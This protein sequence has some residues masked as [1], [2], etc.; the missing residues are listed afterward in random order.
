MLTKLV[1]DIIIYWKLL[2]Y[3]SSLITIQGSEMAI[4]FMNSNFT[5]FVHSLQ[6]ALRY[7]NKAL[8]EESVSGAPWFY[9]I[10]FII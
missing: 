4:I 1:N 8:S 6:A 7:G 2:N 9:I 3:E 5:Q 10:V